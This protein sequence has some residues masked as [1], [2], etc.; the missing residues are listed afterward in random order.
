M[1]TTSCVFIVGA[2]SAGC[3]VAARLSEQYN[4]LLL[5]AG[6]NPPPAANPHFFASYVYTD[7]DI[8]YFFKSVPQSVGL[9]YG[10]VSLECVEHCNLFK[11]Q[12]N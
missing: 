3:V 8:N 7:P 4:V 9:G 10:G 11:L 1:K 12:K 2:G 6:G 5:E